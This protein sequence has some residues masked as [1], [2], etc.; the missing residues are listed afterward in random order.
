M[1]AGQT[2]LAGDTF[3]DATR[4]EAVNLKR[5]NETGKVPLSHQ[6]IGVGIIPNLILNLVILPA[7][8]GVGFVTA[9]FA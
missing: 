6:I 1:E 9:F 7:L 4:G 5:E 8:F 3:G 2:R